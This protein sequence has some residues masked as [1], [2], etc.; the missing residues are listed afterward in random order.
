ME[1]LVWPPLVVQRWFGEWVSISAG[2]R[3]GADEPMCRE[4]ADIVRVLARPGKVRGNRSV[5]I[6]C[7]DDGAFASGKYFG[8]HSRCLSRVAET[9]LNPLRAKSPNR[10]N[11]EVDG[12]RDTNWEEP[13]LARYQWQR[14]NMPGL[15]GED[16]DVLGVPGL[17][18]RQFEDGADLADL[19]QPGLKRSALSH[20]R[21]IE[22][23][24]TQ[25]QVVAT[26]ALVAVPGD[27]AHWRSVAGSLPL[28][29]RFAFRCRWMT[30]RAG[31]HPR[32]FPQPAGGGMGEV[33]LTP[34][35]AADP[36]AYLHPG[37]VSRSWLLAL[38]S[39]VIGAHHWSVWPSRQSMGAMA[40]F[41][42]LMTSGCSTDEAAPD[43]SRSDRAIEHAQKGCKSGQTELSKD[44]LDEFA[45]AARDDSK[46][47]SLYK[48]YSEAFSGNLDLSGIP[49]PSA[50]QDA[51]GSPWS[52][53]NVDKRA[54]QRLHQLAQ[55][56][57]DECR[58]ASIN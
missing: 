46:W 45:R 21:D 27:E 5:Q 7:Q 47:H 17:V 14:L 49:A 51:G 34:V 9:V 3:E 23:Q 25:V 6:S 57:L 30:P 40:C 36:S 50:A 26:E 38:A 2:S 13:W 24:V 8:D 29:A 1:R 18:D 44:A 28:G 42:A 33:R 15:P 19:A 41:I 55:I 48:A 39:V 52:I 56:V 11:G 43:V 35:R 16:T 22:V 4:S 20:H 37:G 32:G 31:V 53:S 58:K 54:S 10:K 12:P